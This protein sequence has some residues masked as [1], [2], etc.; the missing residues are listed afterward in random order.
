MLVENKKLTALV[1]VLNVKLLF[2]FNHIEE[3]DLV[4]LQWILSMNVHIGKLYKSDTMFPL[5]A[6][7][8][9]NIVG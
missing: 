7:M 2:R 8:S 1:K 3:I 6:L 9:T 5:M 4:F